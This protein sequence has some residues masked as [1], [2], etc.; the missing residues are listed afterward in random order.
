MNVQKEWMR[1]FQLKQHTA[2]STVQQ[3]YNKR[4]LKEQFKT[5]GTK[6]IFTLFIDILTSKKASSE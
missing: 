6:S 1:G 3:V 5:S 4:L 2:V